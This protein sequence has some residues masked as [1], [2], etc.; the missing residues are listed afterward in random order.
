MQ[1]RLQSTV[2]AQKPASP[3]RPVPL[4]PKLLSQ[5]GGGA[6]RTTWAKR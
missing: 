4:D 3:S 2:P 1:T 6:P 5:I